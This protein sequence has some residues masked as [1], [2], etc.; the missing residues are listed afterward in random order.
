RLFSSNTE[1]VMLKITSAG[2]VRA[3]RSGGVAVDTT[4]SIS[5]NQWVRIEWHLI[6][7]TTV[8]QWELKLFNNPDSATP[9][10]TATSAA[11]LDT[12]ANVTDLRIGLYGGPNALGPI[13]LDNIVAGATS[14]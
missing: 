3:T 8:G 5:L 4:A 11:N 14:Y 1:V 10:E 6:H 2:N 13:W 9:T 7:S 12:G